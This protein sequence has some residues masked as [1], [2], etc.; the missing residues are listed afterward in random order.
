MSHP[1]G[2]V[3]KAPHHAVARA[4]RLAALVMSRILPRRAAT[5]AMGRTTLA[6]RIK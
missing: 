3:S 4:N 1:G 2:P 6:F 5:E